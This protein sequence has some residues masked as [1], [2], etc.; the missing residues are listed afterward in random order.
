MRTLFFVLLLAL[1]AQVSA[2]SCENTGEPSNCEPESYEIGSV[3]RKEAEDFRS[4]A[5]R[6]TM[7]VRTTYALDAIVRFA[8]FKL[9]Q[10]GSV[11]QAELLLKEWE[12]QFQYSL[13]GIRDIGDHAPL[14]QWLAEKYAVLEFI[15]GEPMCRALRL[16][17]I[18]ILNYAIPVV[19]SC[20]DKVDEAEFELHF[21][22]FAS[23]VV[24]WSSFFGCVGGT[25]GTGFLWCSPIAWGAEFLTKRFVAPAV[26]EPVW[27]L[28]CNKEDF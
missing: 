23:V 3:A 8:A 22:P 15:L 17:D 21:V 14:N 2:L 6:G 4:E 24:Y 12:D 28:S 13:F 18:K 1:L 5:K 26:N 7:S 10:A 9:R 11:D 19:F 27:K 25:W 16:E 20:I